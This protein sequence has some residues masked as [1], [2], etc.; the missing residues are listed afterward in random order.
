MIAMAIT[1]PP[2]PWGKKPPCSHRLLTDAC[3]PPLPL[4]SR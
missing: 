4:T 2:T 3:G 1:N